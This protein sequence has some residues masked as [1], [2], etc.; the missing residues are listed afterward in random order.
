MKPFFTNS[1]GSPYIRVATQSQDLIAQDT[2]TGSLNG[3]LSESTRNGRRDRGFSFIIPFR[4][5]HTWS[6]QFDIGATCM[7]FRG[8]HLLFAASRIEGP[9]RSKLQ[10]HFHS[11]SALYPPY[12]PSTPL[13]S[14]AVDSLSFH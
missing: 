9:E 1:S 8:N 6:A 14:L 13:M 4:D 7:G 11:S 2:S 10:I 3:Y 5:L 12:C